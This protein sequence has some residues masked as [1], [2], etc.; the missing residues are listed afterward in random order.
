MIRSRRWLR[1]ILFLVLGLLVLYAAARLVGRAVSASRL[2]GELERVRATGAP[3]TLAEITPVAVPDA[4]NAAVLLEEAFPLFTKEPEELYE[5]GELDEKPQAWSED[6]AQQHRAWVDQN[7]A[8]IA[9]VEEAVRRPLCHFERDL[10]DGWASVAN[11]VPGVQGAARLLSMRGSLEIRDGDVDG[12]LATSGSLVRLGRRTRD[13]ASFIDWLVGIG[14]EELG[15]ELARQALEAGSPSAD[16]LRDL[17]GVVEALPAEETLE[18]VF[19]FERAFGLWGYDRIEAADTPEEEELL[20]GD[21]SEF[22][23]AVRKFLF[24]DT[25]RRLDQARYLSLMARA[26]E[27]A[28]Q[29]FRDSRDAWRQLQTDGREKHWYDGLAGAAV[30]VN[31]LVARAWAVYQVRADL[32][33]LAL[34]VELHEQEHGRLPESIASLDV[35]GGA[36]DRLGDAAYGYRPEADGGYVLYS[37]GPDGVDDGGRETDNP[38]ESGDVAWRRSPRKPWRRSRAPP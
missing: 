20:L 31:P 13:Y 15:L 26:L 16:A 29:P 11:H 36:R 18:R 19:A 27:L 21:E 2:E 9:H 22:G 30:S 3:L 37:V 25:A 14:I 4:E 23:S 38:R 17:L 8:G 28:S 34:R 32:A 35:P 24:P 1:R 10:S 7:D 5:H 33:G 12:A 6:V